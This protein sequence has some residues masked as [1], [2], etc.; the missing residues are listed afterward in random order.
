MTEQNEQ[1]NTLFPEK[2]EE[3]PEE[4]DFF[5]TSMK[6]NKLTSSS[7]LTTVNPKTKKSSV[8]TLSVIEN[9]D[10]STVVD[11][12]ETSNT[13]QTLND[14]NNIASLQKKTKQSLAKRIIRYNAHRKTAD[15]Y[16]K[17][18]HSDPFATLLILKKDTQQ[19][20]KRRAE[21]IQELHQTHLKES[22]KS[23]YVKKDNINGDDDDNDD[24]DE[25]ITE[26]VVD[27][28]DEKNDDKDK[29]ESVEKTIKTDLADAETF[30]L[31]ITKLLKLDF[32]SSSALGAWQ[33]SLL[34]FEKNL[35]PRKQQQQ[36]Q[37][38]QILNSPTHSLD[39]TTSNETK[40]IKNVG[41]I[42]ENS[43]KEY[44]QRIALKHNIFFVE[45]YNRIK[46]I[47]EKFSSIVDTIKNKNQ[48]NVNE[49]DMT[50]IVKI[51]ELYLPDIYYLKSSLDKIKHHFTGNA[52]SSVEF[53]EEQCLNSHVRTV[54]SCG[55]FENRFQQQ[56]GLFSSKK[57][58]RQQ[59]E[60]EEDRNSKPSDEKNTFYE[61]KNIFQQKKTTDDRHDKIEIEQQFRKRFLVKKPYLSYT[62]KI[63][64]TTVFN[65]KNNKR[66]RLIFQIMNNNNNTNNINPHNVSF[67]KV[68]C[69]T[70]M[71]SL[72]NILFHLRLLCNPS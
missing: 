7:S 39:K 46:L 13:N 59:E 62:E 67:G 51:I 52:E 55:V 15:E 53:Y 21:L 71:Q 60:E 10:S 30:I 25:D 61:T 16:L 47:I 22:S 68:S 66:K 1:E 8:A 35:S 2:N 5:L 57:K 3:N 56:N 19:E 6:K 18:I 40:K 23:S 63:K 34:S 69:E 50:L 44:D 32:G 45:T 58:K 14:D 65:S 4:D 12:S 37:N 31:F 28:E 26:N 48:S 27:D 70:N 24:K 54:N 36:Q 29:E 33:Q 17:K 49:N 72:V 38:T 43:L 20:I 64:L 11:V 41:K 42:I 9:D